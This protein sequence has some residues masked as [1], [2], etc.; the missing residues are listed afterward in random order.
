MLGAR[1]LFFLRSG[2]CLLVLTSLWST[3]KFICQ[4]SCSG[5]SYWSVGSRIATWWS[6]L[7]CKRGE[8]CSSAG[9]GAEGLSPRRRFRS[10]DENS[11]QGKKERSAC[12]RDAGAR[13]LGHIGVEVTTAGANP[14]ES[15]GLFASHW[16]LVQTATSGLPPLE[17]SCGGM[18]H[19]H[20]LV[21][22]NLAQLDAPTS[23]LPAVAQ[24]DRGLGSQDLEQGML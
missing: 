7:R 22:R 14:R 13:G 19:E 23:W 11:A 9:R 18:I 1:L 15:A 21:T 3:A 10:E 16:A 2:P 12:G 17:N 24:A 8:V 5:R 4:V 20:S 6:L